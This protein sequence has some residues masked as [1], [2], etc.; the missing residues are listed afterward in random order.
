MKLELLT[1]TATAS[2]P[3]PGNILTFSLDRDPS[4]AFP[5]GAVMDQQSGIFTWTP[6]EVQ[7]PDVYT[8]TVRVTDSGFP[9]LSAFEQVRITVAEVNVAPV[10]VDDQ[11]ETDEDTPLVVE[12]PGVLDNDHDPDLPANPLTVL[13]DSGPAHGVIQLSPDGSFT[14]TPTLNFHGTDVFTY[15]LSDGLVSDLA[16]VTITVNQIHFPQ[17]DLAVSI[18]S[19]SQIAAG[20][21]VRYTVTTTNQGPSAASGVSLAF[22]L[23]A[24]TSLDSAPGGCSLA[25]LVVT[26]SIG[27]LSSGETA[28]RLISAATT[29][30]MSGNITAT[31]VVSGTEA[32]PVSANNTATRTV[33]VMA[34]VDI[35]TTGFE[36]L[37]GRNGLTPSPPQPPPVKCS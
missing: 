21:K 9:P 15:S 32:D 4:A 2:D 29:A 14:Y 25:G 31:A 12:T 30:A 28:V 16:K 36:V 13:L 27:S 18:A 19:H 7:G 5:T 11:Y 34:I 22:T 1:F 20:G 26:C 37:P 23:P 8:V 17:A 24:G 10:A 35:Y 3:D 33:N 6:L